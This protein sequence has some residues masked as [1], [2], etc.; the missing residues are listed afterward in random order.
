MVKL[1]KNAQNLHSDYEQRGRG[2]RTKSLTSKCLFDN[3]NTDF[4]DDEDFEALKSSQKKSKTH[5]SVSFPDFPSIIK[6]MAIMM[7]LHTFVIS[8]KRMQEIVTKIVLFRIKIMEYWLLDVEFKLYEF[9]DEINSILV[10]TA[11]CICYLKY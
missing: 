8:T 1:A 7:M 10:F 3:L 5:L 9:E 6:G 4:S 2:K 11:V